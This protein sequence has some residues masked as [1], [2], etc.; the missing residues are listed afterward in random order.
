[1]NKSPKCIEQQHDLCDGNIIEMIND[2]TE[3]RICECQCHDY[4]YKLVSRMQA[5]NNQ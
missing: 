2:T 3:T 5:A 4:M 1:M